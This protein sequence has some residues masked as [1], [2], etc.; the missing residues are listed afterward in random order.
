MRG[1]LASGKEDVPG[2]LSHLKSTLEK[3]AEEPERQQE[4]D[5][6]KVELKDLNVGDLAIEYRK[7]YDEK[8]K[9]NQ[10]ISD[11]NIKLDAAGQ[12]LLENLERQGLEQLRTTDGSTTLFIKDDVY[13]KQQN[14]AE[15]L[16]WIK[17]NGMEDLLTV[18]YSTMNA[19]T[20][21]R[22]VKGQPVPPG[23]Q[24]YFKQSIRI[25]RNTK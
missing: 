5:Q 1:L 12:L 24:A 11:L 7:W 16:D 9:L 17:K 21:D 23:I 4:L 8:E 13:C 2:Q 3:V 22:L 19:Q 25:R 15:Y 6:V 10:A 18:H 14:R 20:T